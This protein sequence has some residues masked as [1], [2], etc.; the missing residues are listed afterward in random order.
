MEILASEPLNTFRRKKK[1]ETELP[2]KQLQEV[3][4]N[5]TAWLAFSF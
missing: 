4:F 5:E 3:H 1:R 2:S